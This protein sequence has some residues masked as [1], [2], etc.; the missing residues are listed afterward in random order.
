MAANRG[1]V[2]AARALVGVDEGAHAEDV[3][4]RTAPREGSDRSL[5][6][7]LALGVLRRRAHVDAALAPLLRQPLGALDPEVRASLRLGAFEVLFA[8]TRPHAAVH[9]AVEVVRALG[10]GRAS[11]LVNAVLRKVRAPSDLTRAQALDHPPWLVAR[12][13]ARYGE[14]ATEAWCR[15]NNE[16]AVLFLVARDDPDALAAD[17]R[18]A[19]YE[20]EPARLHGA[21][22]P[23]VLRLAGGGAVPDLPGFAE[24]RFW[25]Q[26]AA[27]VAVADL[28]PA[29][30]GTRVLDACAAPGGK[31]FRLA[32]RGARVLAADTARDRL[33]AVRVSAKRLRLHIDTVR[34]DW[35]EGS[36][37]D[38]SPFDAVLVDAPCTALGLC[39]R[40]PEIRWRRQLLDVLKMPNRQ[41]P[42]LARAATHV[43]PG[44]VLVYAVCSP[45]PEEGP[46]VIDSF[47]AENPDFRLDTTFSTAPPEGDEDAFFAARLLRAEAP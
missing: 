33:D 24:G 29:G 16:P 36:L 27:S 21:V 47:L 4:A 15:R 26:D 23:G 5:A 34:H 46:A 37:D 3:L 31:S 11:G 1:R 18:A 14:A 12:W 22:S 17:W 25:V 6:W 44:G 45:E 10:A 43:R 35:L 8:R 28:V 38:V 32:A 20:V 2:A 19:G 42:I 41:R 30:E 40:H 7:F 9:Q 13:D 39:R